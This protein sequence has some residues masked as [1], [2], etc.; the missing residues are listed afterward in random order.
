RAAIEQW[1][2]DGDRRLGTALR[3]SL[4]IYLLAAGDE[5]GAR[6][7]LA[8]LGEPLP[9]DHLDRIVGLG[10]GELCQSVAGAFPIERPPSWLAARLQRSLDL[11]SDWPNT[12]WLAASLA[13]AKY[14]SDKAIQ[15]L[16]KMQDLV[17][18]PAQ[19]SGPLQALAQQFP[20]DAALQVFVRQT[21]ATQPATD[22]APAL[23]VPVL[24]FPAP[25]SVPPTQSPAP[26]AS[27][28]RIGGLLGHPQGDQGGQVG[29]GKGPQEADSPFIERPAASRPTPGASRE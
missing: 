3:R 20:S 24:P 10:L 28:T 13:L 8:S 1:P 15:H 25:A 4:S 27:P 7:Q 29:P 16:R 2:A 23:T 22:V 11:V 17:G 9:G 21:L 6:R 26:G 14:E 19:M 5:A 12:R 18:G